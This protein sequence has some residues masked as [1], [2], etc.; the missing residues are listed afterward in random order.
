MTISDERSRLAV[1]RDLFGAQSSAATDMHLVIGVQGQDDCAVYDLPGNLSL[2]IGSDFVRGTGFALFQEGLLSYFDIGYYLVVANLSDIAAMGATPTGLTTVIRYPDFLSDA[3][4]R[5]LVLGIKEA[6]AL[7]QTPIVGGDIGGYSE[8]VLAATAFG[9][10]ERGKYLSRQG[11]RVG[12]F[13]CTTGTLG[14]PSTALAY[15]TKAKKQGFLLS[16]EEEQLLLNS[17]R[18][19]V[20]H[21]SSGIALAQSGF[22]HACQDVSDG[23]KATIEQLAQASS[24]SF[25]VF[26]AQ[27]PLSPITY[28]VA[29][30]LRADPISLAFSASVDFQLMFT[31]NQESLD[32]LRALEPLA[33]VALLGQAIPVSEPSRLIRNSGQPSPIPGTAWNQQRKNVVDVILEGY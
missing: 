33:G 32:L 11:T 28:K 14:L 6:A 4:F 16:A 17:W 22:V 5:Q 31:V 29:E 21:I 1:I 7:Y 9:I 20:A 30:A 27:L 10:T 25:E 18:R 24:L 12:D 26:E 13:L 8:M 19:P 2:V 3:D 23:A 15:F